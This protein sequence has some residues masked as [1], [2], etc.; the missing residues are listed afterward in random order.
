MSS[1]PVPVVSEP[2]VPAA[3][4]RRLVCA[5]CGA[6][7]AGEYCAACGQRHEPH[8]HTVG[9]F[10]AEAFESITHAD[11]RLWRTLWYL[12]ARPGR[13]TR[14]FFAGQARPLPAAISPVPG[15]SACCSSWWRGC[16]TQINDR[17]RR[18]IRQRRRDHERGRRGA[19]ERAGRRAGGGAGGRRDPRGDGEG[20]RPGGDEGTRAPRR[21]AGQQPDHRDLQGIR[22]A[23]SHREQELRQAARVL[24][25]HRRGSRPRARRSGGAQHSARHVRVPAAAGAG[26]E[27][28]VLA[29]EALLRRAPA[30]PGPQ[31]RLRVPG[32]DASSGCCK[33]IPVVGAHLGPARV[34][35]LAVHRSGTSFAPCASTTPSRAA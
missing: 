17:H 26:H 15:R 8:V 10:A 21:H 24:Q 34:R 32:A 9:H 11:S 33:L 19:G 35:G 25:A 5:N 6:P 28:D 18:H 1:P 20:S 2:Q 29:A 3:R 27:A 16:R 7:L 31:P 23:R 13:L 14:E 22:Q 12:L 30:V 4:R